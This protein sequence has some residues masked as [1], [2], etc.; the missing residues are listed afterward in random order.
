MKSLRLAILL[1]LAL[2]LVVIFPAS[3]QLGDTDTSSFTVQNIG[4]TDA[5][6]S[7]TFVAADGT[8][9][10][11]TDL[12]N[13]ITNPFTLAPAAAKQIV[14]SQIPSAQLPSG[15]YAVVISSD[16]EVVAQA[17]LAGAG[18][19]HFQ[20]AYTGFSSGAT[21]V[22]IPT[23]AYD[24]FGWYSMISVQ[25]LGTDVADVTVTIAC[26]GGSAAGDTA[27]L[28]TTDLP[29]NASYTWAL[30]N[31]VPTGLVAGDT[32][33]GS[34]VVTSDQPVVAVNNQ[35]NPTT[36][37]ASIGST[38][39]FEG[40]VAGSDVVY[41]G[42][43]SKNYFGWRSALTIQA[44]GLGAGDETIVTIDYA[45]T[46]WDNDTCTLNAAT[47]SCKLIT[48]TDANKDDGRYAA[49]ISSDDATP[50]L[51]VVGSTND[52]AVLNGNSVS[53]SNAVIGVGSGTNTVAIPNIAKGYFGF[54]SAITCQN[55]GAVDTAVNFSFSGYE[56]DAF[57]SAVLAPGESIQVVTTSLDFLVAPYNGGATLTAVDTAG[58]IYCFAGNTNDLPTYSGDWTSTFNGFGYDQ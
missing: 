52:T 38:N 6:V 57:D 28:S 33:D 7:V 17:G 39:S 47:P 23:V 21:T 35:N 34:A 54:K 14:V 18:S 46:A 36:G 50:L 43:V 37:N 32:C 45:G 1:A 15:S 2:V 10:T 3:A 42:G 44:L 8:E 48:V 12:G 13:S 41:V 5:T 51:A 25:N 22:Y 56:S 26:T 58:Q 53:L 20:G 4:A 19:T 49:T 40:S 16:V 27:T 30:K 9:Y 24:F 11:P 29:V 55:V 31:V